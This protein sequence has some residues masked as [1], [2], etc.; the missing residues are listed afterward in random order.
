MA[1]WCKSSSAKGMSR[2][3]DSDHHRTFHGGVRPVH[4]PV[5]LQLR[6][7]TEHAGGGRLCGALMGQR[8]PND[9][10]FAPG[11]TTTSRARAAVFSSSTS[12]GKEAD[13]IL[14]CARDI[15]AMASGDAAAEVAKLLSP[16]ARKELADARQKISHIVEGTKES[17]GG[18]F[19]ES[20]LDS[21]PSI[22]ASAE[23]PEPSK[24]DLNLVALNQAIP[25]VGFGFMDNAILIVAGD[26]IDTSLGVLLG[27]STLFAAAVGNILSDVAG[28]MLGTVIEDFCAKLGLP[29]PNITAAQRQL[30]SVRFA[31]QFGCALGITIGCIIGMFPLYFIDTNKVQKLKQDAHMDSIFRD[32]VKEAKG[33]IGAESTCLFLVVDTPSCTSPSSPSHGSTLARKD[34]GEKYLYRKYVDASSRNEKGTWVPL[35]KGIVSRAALSGE[36]VNVYDARTEPDFDIHIHQ[37]IPSEKI[38]NILCVP[39]F[40]A[41]GDVIA[42]IQAVNKIAVGSATG[43]QGK[44]SLSRK[45]QGFTSNDMQVLQALAAHVSVS[46]QSMHEEDA[47]I[48]LSD[49]IKVLKEHGTDAI[50]DHP[51]SSGPRRR[52]PLFPEPQ[53]SQ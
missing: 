24:H 46:L 35:G 2:N 40:D 26:A 52:R 17:G 28:V 42:V 50:E 30:R 45:G 31:G 37:Q 14:S 9:L 39:V 32:M 47:V 5:G 53:A 11:T 51:T 36:A 23:V 33:L 27:I 10:R 8:T 3:R 1:V 21:G 4:Y 20:M 12:E 34:P 22:A 13:S 48:S 18:G 43:T 16:S 6:S 25:F 19:M 41:H 44:G 38:K 29:V 49:T 15:S 7:V